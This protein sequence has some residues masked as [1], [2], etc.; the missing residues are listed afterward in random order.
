[1]DSEQDVNGQPART[2]S[3]ATREPEPCSSAT[4]SAALRAAMI[5]MVF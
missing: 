3:A 1:M 5:Q 4:P 2:C